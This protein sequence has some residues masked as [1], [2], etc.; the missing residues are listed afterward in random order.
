MSDLINSNSI[1]P[2][3][4]RVRY[5]G[6]NPRNFDEKYKELDP[7]HYAKDVSKILQG[8]K[9]LAGSHRPVCVKEVLEVLDPRPGQSVLDATLGYGG[10]AQELLMR[11]TPGGCLWA[12]D[13][14]PIEIKRTEAR[15]RALGY[16][17]DMLKV[18]RLNFAGVPKILAEAGGGFDLILVDLGVSSMQLDDPSRGFTFK[19]E[20]P[21]DLR[22]NPERGQPASALLKTLSEEGFEKILRDHSDE[23]YAKGIAKSVF[24]CSKGIMTTIAL[25]DAV[26][27]ALPRASSDDEEKERTRSIRRTF[28]ALRIAVNE[29]FS[30]LETFLR[31][32]PL[33]LNSGGRVAIL[34][35]HSGED[36][37]V[38]RAF[39]AGVEAG[40]YAEI[41][42]EPIRATA[43]E[44]YD[45]PRSKSA[46]L[47]WAHRSNSY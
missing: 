25:A 18:R 46:I 10:H 13:V 36:D 16:G 2:Q 35:F 45:N 31:N 44:R 17:E 26:R 21:L 39:K 33:C 11:I 34:T 6:K 9:T 7:E 40:V 42:L 14:D 27:R 41:S 20:G 32:L 47:R 23:P 1:P 28:Q 4:R 3:K 22:L 5:K 19:K 12:I 8:G 30:V 24:K 38:M 15:L 29:E 43:Q 37:R